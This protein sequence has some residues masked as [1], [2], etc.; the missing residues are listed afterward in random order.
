MIAH[1][2]EIFQGCARFREFWQNNFEFQILWS[3]SSEDFHTFT[4]QLPI[5][6]LWRLNSKFL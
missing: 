3:L 4:L 2:H 6:T 5:Q 1:K